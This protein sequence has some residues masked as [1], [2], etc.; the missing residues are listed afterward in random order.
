MFMGI[1]LR[2]LT[3]TAYIV[4]AVHERPGSIKSVFRIRQGTL[5]MNADTHLN[6]FMRF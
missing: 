6:V 3:I 2:Q 4:G 1:S 5:L